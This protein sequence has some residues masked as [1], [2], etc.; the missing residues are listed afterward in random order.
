MHS[1]VLV[2]ALLFASSNLDKKDANQARLV[3]LIAL[4][5]LPMML[6]G[7]VKIL[8]RYKI[9]FVDLFGLT[10]LLSACLTP[11][12]L[13]LTNWIEIGPQQKIQLDLSI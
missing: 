8:A 3:F 11:I 1:I 5:G 9:I 13:S 6:L 4:T 7:L 12:I 2:A 10:Y